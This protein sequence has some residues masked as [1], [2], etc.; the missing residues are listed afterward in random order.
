MKH[1]MVGVHLFRPFYSLSRQALT[2]HS[3]EF[4]FLDVEPVTAITL[5]LIARRIRRGQNA[6]QAVLV[7]FEEGKADADTQAIRFAVPVQDIG[8]H[9]PMQLLRALTR[10]LRRA[11][12][13]Q[14]AELI[15]PSRARVSRPR[16]WSLRRAAIWR[17]ARS[18]AA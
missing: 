8:F 14:Q 6:V 7:R 2:K 10:T 4:D 5:G 17:M 9:R 12:F 11:A 13:Q 1:W 3:V 16:T 15:P 18:P